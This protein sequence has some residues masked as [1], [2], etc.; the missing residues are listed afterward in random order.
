LAAAALTHVAPLG[1]D[2]FY[3]QT[4][5]TSWLG[6]QGFKGQAI[7]YHAFS[8]AG[9][10]EECKLDVSHD[11]GHPPEFTAVKWMPTAHWDTELTPFVWQPKRT[12]YDALRDSVVALTQ[13][14][15]L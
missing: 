12:M 11:A 1:A 13:S 3:Y 10:V 7:R 6:K 5:P 14:V 15:K 9:Q 2:V 8:W 4:P